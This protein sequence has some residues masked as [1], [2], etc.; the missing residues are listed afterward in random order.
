MA[1][2]RIFRWLLGSFISRNPADPE[3]LQPVP[4]AYADGFAVAVP[5]FRLLMPALLPAFMIVDS[6]AGL[7]LN[8]QKC[9]LGSMWQRQMSRII[10]F[11]LH[12]LWLVS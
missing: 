4:C 10:G 7:N 11:G 2:D 1:F 5:S 8:H 9:F 12:K 3:F 6:I